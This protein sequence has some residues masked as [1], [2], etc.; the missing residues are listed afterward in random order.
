MVLII[1]MFL[2]QEVPWSFHFVCL[3][4]CLF[5]PRRWPDISDL[6]SSGV[7]HSKK[8]MINKNKFLCGYFFY[9]SR[10][11]FSTVATAA[12]ECG[13]ATGF[14]S[15]GSAT[16]PTKPALVCLTEIVI[17]LF[18]HWNDGFSSTTQF[19]RPEVC[20]QGVGRVGSFSGN[21]FHASSPASGGCQQSSAPR[22]LS[23]SSLSICLHT[24]SS[25]L[26]ICVF[27]LLTRTPALISTNCICPWSYWQI[28]S[29]S[30]VSGGHKFGGHNT[31][32]T[33]TKAKI[34]KVR[35]GVSR[36]STSLK[37]QVPKRRAQSPEHVS[38]SHLFSAG[39]CWVRWI[40]SRV[41]HYNPQLLV[42]TTLVPSLCVDRTCDYFHWTMESNEM[43]HTPWVHQKGRE[44]GDFLMT[45]EP[46]LGWLHPQLRDPIY[47]WPIKALCPPGQ[48]DQ[49][50]K[51]TIWPNH[52]NQKYPIP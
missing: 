27:P 14:T 28:R 29:Y 32:S 35:W 45:Q 50:E 25:P 7:P 30:K 8:G 4:A 43:P 40:K 2:S 18:L 36:G 26:P 31:F 1:A 21:M 13:N 20:S 9:N 24:A 33:G 51:K 5:T 38:F 12:S 19:W 22:H 48:R 44:T 34:K 42:I 17:M 16:L 6:Q 10:N 47:G 37:H 11:L 41:A 39:P 3:F 15:A 46:H 23:L 52:T 49:S